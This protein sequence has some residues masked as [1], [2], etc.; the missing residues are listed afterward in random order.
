MC[1]VAPRGARRNT[2]HVCVVVYCVFHQL[3][4]A[5]VARAK[6]KAPTAACHSELQR[7]N[8]KNNPNF[9]LLGQ[10]NNPDEK[11]SALHFPSWNA[12]HKPNL[13]IT[14]LQA[15]GLDLACHEIVSSGK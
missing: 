1:S 2:G 7:R 9:P 15:R 14:H 3:R 8:H 12:L 4:C 11:L 5:T 6:L 10:G 13:C